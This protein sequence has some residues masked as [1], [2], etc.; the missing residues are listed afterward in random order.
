MPGEHVDGAAFCSNLVGH[1]WLRDPAGRA[2]RANQLIDELCVG[3]IEQT[4][5][6]LALPED[7]DLQPTAKCIRDLDNRS[8]RERVRLTAFDPR[9]RRSG[10][11]DASAELRLRPAPPATQRPQR[12]PQTNRIHATRRIARAAYSPLHA[13]LTRSGWYRRPRAALP[14]RARFAWT[15]S[16]SRRLGQPCIRDRTCQDS[17]GRSC[18]RWGHSP[19]AR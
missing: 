6:V 1:L 9:D 11:A 10:D 14:V 3:A 4:V 2:Q 15:A 17:R 13:R 8:Q 5:Q 19:P 12:Q 16:S 7:A 18:T